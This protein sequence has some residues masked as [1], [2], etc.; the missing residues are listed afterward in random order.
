[1]FFGGP[2]LPRVAG[3]KE[4]DRDYQA[5]VPVLKHLKRRCN[6]VV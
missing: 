3:V 2:N 4:N 6:W 1:M 5:L